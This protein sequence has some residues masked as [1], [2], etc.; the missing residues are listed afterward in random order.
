MPSYLTSGASDVLASYET[1][2]CK[3]GDLGTA[4]KTGPWPQKLAGM[5]CRCAA[6]LA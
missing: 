1:L 3:Q 4:M 2:V 6:G 5:R